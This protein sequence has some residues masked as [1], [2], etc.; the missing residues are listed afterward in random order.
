MRRVNSL[1]LQLEQQR[2]CARQRLATID[3]LLDKHE[4]GKDVVDDAKMRVRV[5]LVRLHNLSACIAHCRGLAI[6]PLESRAYQTIT[7]DHATAFLLLGAFLE[8]DFAQDVLLL[9]E[10]VVVL[11]VVVVR[12]VKHAV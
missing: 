4:F 12:L 11:H 5:V 8:E 7:L 10:R 6:S 3:G 2:L 1:K 9:A